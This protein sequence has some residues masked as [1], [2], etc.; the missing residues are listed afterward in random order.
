M[1]KKALSWVKN[2]INKIMAKVKQT[3]NKIKELGAKLFEKLFEFL[4]MEVSTVRQT[5]PTDI[6]GF[7]YVMK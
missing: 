1:G 4:G 6:A 3:L 2:L 5:I 7:V